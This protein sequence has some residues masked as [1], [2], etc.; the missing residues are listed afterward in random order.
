MVPFWAFNAFIKV[1][2]KFEGDNNPFLVFFL[3]QITQ[4][5]ANKTR[6]ETSANLA[7]KLS[8]LLTL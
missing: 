3:R 2:G 8:M 1:Y 7:L 6:N 4:H 5:W